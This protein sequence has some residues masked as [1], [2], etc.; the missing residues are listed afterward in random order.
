MHRQ[1]GGGADY[2]SGVDERDL[3]ATMI[4]T[5]RF[6]VETKTEEVAALVDE[7]S[8]ILRPQIEA[9]SLQLKVRLADQSST[10]QCDRERVLQVIANLVGNAIKFT[11]EGGRD[12]HSRNG[13]GRCSVLF[14]C[15]RR[16]DYRLIPAV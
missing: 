15:Q 7:A 16:P 13:R 10:V 4:E 14:G 8:K 5:G 1:G 11:K 6:T 3:D 9:R 2:A 12:L